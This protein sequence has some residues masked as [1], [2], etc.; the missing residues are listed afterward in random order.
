MAR[1]LGTVTLPVYVRV[2]D[3][4]EH[5]VGTITLDVTYGTADR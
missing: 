5:E 3:G 4:D 1:A 2:G